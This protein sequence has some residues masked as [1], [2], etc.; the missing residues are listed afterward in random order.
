MAGIADQADGIDPL[1]SRC[2]PPIP[3]FAQQGIRLFERSSRSRGIVTI[4]RRHKTLEPI[5]RRDTVVID[6]G[7]KIS[8]RLPETVISSP[9]RPAPIMV[10]DHNDLIGHPRL[11]GQSGP[12]AH[13][14][15]ASQRRNDDRNP[16]FV[17]L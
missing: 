1:F 11:F 6:K 14:R 5:F 17:A 3:D 10:Q 2:W 4:N 15:V 16:V 12:A 8:R 7:D 13:Q 9:C